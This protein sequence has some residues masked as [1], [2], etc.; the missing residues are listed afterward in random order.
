MRFVLRLLLIL[1][2][3]SCSDEKYETLGEI[4]YRRSGERCSPD[5]EQHWLLDIEA[6]S[7]KDSIYLNTRELKRKVEVPLNQVDTFSNLYTLLSETC[8]GDSIDLQ[9]KAKEFYSSLNGKVP[10]Y[11]SQDELIT[12]KVV[13]VDKLSTLGYIGYKK[14]FESNLM[15]RYTEKNRWNAQ[16]DTATQVYYELLKK[17]PSGNSDFSKARVAYS[18]SSLGGEVL[19]FSREDS[20]LFLD[21]NDKGLLPGIRFLANQ[22]GAGESLRAVIPSNMAFGAGGNKMIPGY[23]PLLIEMEV[24]EVIE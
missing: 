21:K 7:A 9:L 5:E 3:A 2:I 14:A 12:V 17:N 23:T 19:A 8:E 6:R 11:L 16:L 15:A 22:I 20:P 24:I 18:I 10:P 1:A 13:V 4:S